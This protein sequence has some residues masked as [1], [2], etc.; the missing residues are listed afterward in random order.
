[1]QLS[2]GDI[3]SSRL[4]IDAMGNFS[5]ILKQVIFTFHLHELNSSLAIALL[6]TT[7]E[8][9]CSWYLYCYKRLKVV[10]SQMECAL[11]LDLVLM[12]LRRTHQ[13]MSFIVVHQ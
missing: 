10:E 11:L 6:K 9:Y 8:I 7:D 2:K 5:P 13:A 1:M 3:L 12:V 4:V